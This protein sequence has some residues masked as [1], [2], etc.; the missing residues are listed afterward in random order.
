MIYPLST[1]CIVRYVEN[2]GEKQSRS[3]REKITKI[4]FENECLD[5]GM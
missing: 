3:L 1:S 4:K 2:K 5:H